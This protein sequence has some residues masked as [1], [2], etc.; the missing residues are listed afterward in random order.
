MQ[1]RSAV[2][3]DREVGRE[4][5]V[6]VHLHLA[7]GIADHADHGV[8]GVLILVKC[9]GADEAQGDV[10]RRVKQVEEIDLVVLGVLEILDDVGMR[11]LAIAELLVDEGVGA[12][13]ACPCRRHRSGCRRRQAP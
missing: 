1:R 5:G 10:V 4:V 2:H 9:L 11:R 3:H 8:M 13:E 12:E 6:D 7:A